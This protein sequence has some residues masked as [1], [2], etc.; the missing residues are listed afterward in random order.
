[1]LIIKAPTPG[2]Q[3]FRLSRTAFPVR[4]A[5]L[6]AGK[7]LSIHLPSCMAVCLSVHTHSCIYGKIDTQIEKTDRKRDVKNPEVFGECG[8]AQMKLKHNKPK[9]RKNESILAN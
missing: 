1:M 4:K 8:T 7:F 5:R 2:P 3:S 9:P 6:Q